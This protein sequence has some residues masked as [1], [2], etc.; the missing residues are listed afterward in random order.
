MTNPQQPTSSWALEQGPFQDSK[1]PRRHDAA[2]AGHQ[3]DA[4]KRQTH[5]QRFSPAMNRPFRPSTVAS[6]GGAAGIPDI[7]YSQGSP[8]LAKTRSSRRRSALQGILERSKKKQEKQEQ[9]A[10]HG[11]A[12]H[13]SAK[14]SAYNHTVN[15]P[16]LP[17]N[18]Q[19][20]QHAPTAVVPSAAAGSLSL[21]RPVFKAE[22]QFRSSPVKS[23]QRA[24]NLG[25]APRPSRP[26]LLQ[27]K[28]AEQSFKPLSTSN[29]VS[30]E[31]GGSGHGEAAASELGLMQPLA[32]TSLKQTRQYPYRVERSYRIVDHKRDD[33]DVVSDK[34][35]ESSPPSSPL[36]P[37]A[38]PLQVP[39]SLPPV[40]QPPPQKD[41]PPLPPQLQQQLQQLPRLSPPRKLPYR[42][43]QKSQLGLLEPGG[44]PAGNLLAQ[45]SSRRVVSGSSIVR[46]PSKLSIVDN[47]QPGRNVQMV[48]V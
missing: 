43:T 21:S 35:P 30:G 4:A 5:Q 15:G 13:A 9:M 23:E 6:D 18:S 46:A 41:L 8:L 27:Q 1:K 40:Q 3:T 20:P 48:S 7:V 12:R 45:N 34:D 31:D 38:T 22:L 29:G 37:T 44:G 16:P 24:N 26:S 11:G 14:A 42:N 36:S 25:L 47:S 19:Q 2:A 39:V 10:M 28:R 17:Q 33:A 32:T